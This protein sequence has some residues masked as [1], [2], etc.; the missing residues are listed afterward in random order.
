MLSD[1]DPKNAMKVTGEIA[2]LLAVIT[3]Q[4]PPFYIFASLRHVSTQNVARTNQCVVG[5]CAALIQLKAFFYCG[6]SIA[7]ADFGVFNS[8]TE[9]AVP[10]IFK[11]GQLDVMVNVGC[12]IVI[13]KIGPEKGIFTK[14]SH[15]FSG[16]D[17]M[18]F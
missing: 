18:R 9:K 1:L 7:D 3:E 8:R 14:G 10:K 15:I 16:C 17:S 6:Q 5:Q 2:D 12:Y 11:G 13:H 4:C